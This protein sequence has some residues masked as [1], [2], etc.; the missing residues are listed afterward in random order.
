[1]AIIPK[2]PPIFS[3]FL[4]LAFSLSGIQTSHAIR[5]L[6]QLPDVPPILSA[7]LPTSPVISGETLTTPLLPLPPPL[8]DAATLFGEPLLPP[9]ASSLNLPFVQPST[10]ALPSLPTFPTLLPPPMN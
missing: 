8:P 9:P 2:S 6:Q 4:F 10:N 7:V 3:I 1:M 5:V